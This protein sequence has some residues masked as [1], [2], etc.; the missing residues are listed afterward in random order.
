MPVL[1]LVGDLQQRG[2]LGRG[3]RLAIRPSSPVRFC[4]LMPLALAL[5]KAAASAVNVALVFNAVAPQDD[6]RL[7]AVLPVV[8]RKP[9]EIARSQQTVRDDWARALAKRG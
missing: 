7:P 4:A 8:E 2:L 6:D 5:A 3:G 1:T 9:L